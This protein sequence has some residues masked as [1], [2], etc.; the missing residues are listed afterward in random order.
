[1]QMQ[2]GSCIAGFLTHFNNYHSYYNKFCKG[3]FVIQVSFHALFL[4]GNCGIDDWEIILIDIGRHEQES[5]RKVL[6]L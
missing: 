6:F 1:M 4:D 3:H 2:A 5:R